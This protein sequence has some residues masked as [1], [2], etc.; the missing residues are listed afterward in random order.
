MSIYIILHIY[1]IYVV[2]RVKKNRPVGRC[3]NHYEDYFF[4]FVM[5]SL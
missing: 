4:A 1:V 3:V 5:Y 2:F